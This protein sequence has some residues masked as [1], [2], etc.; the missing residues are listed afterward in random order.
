LGLYGYIFGVIGLF[1]HLMS[2][3]SFGVPYM[4]NLVSTKLQDI[5]DTSI[6]APWWY[7]QYRPKFIS[8]KNRI[9]KKNSTR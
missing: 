9:R 5:K 8:S 2:M 4:M 3:R 1:I 6:R 7:M